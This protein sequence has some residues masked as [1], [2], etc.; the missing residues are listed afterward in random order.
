MTD[1]TKLTLKKI[2]LFFAAF[3]TLM[4]AIC[5]TVFPIVNGQPAYAVFNIVVCGVAGVAEYMAIK[6]LGGLVNR[7]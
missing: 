3:A 5:N 6:K 4:A 7:D 2:A 1:D